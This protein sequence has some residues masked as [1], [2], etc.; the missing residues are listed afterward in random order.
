MVTIAGAPLSW[1]KSMKSNDEE[2]KVQRLVLKSKTELNV[3]YKLIYEAVTL[4]LAWQYYALG[5]ILWAD[6]MLAGW[7]ICSDLF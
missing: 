2:T 7:L 5:A 4:K 3:L 6:G 1:E